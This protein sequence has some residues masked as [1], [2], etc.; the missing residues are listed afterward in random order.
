M[1]KLGIVL[2][3]LVLLLF[4]LNSFAQDICFDEATAG[5][6]IVAL[7]QAKI[8]SQQLEVQAGSNSELQQQLEI[9]KGTIKL[10]EDQ[11]VVYKNIQDMNKQMSDA[12][13]KLHEQELKAVKP[14]FWD[15]MQKYIVG[16]GIGAAVAVAI[17]LIL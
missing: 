8:A 16:G 13:D 1:K 9:L 14:T 10:M 11:I 4:P 5:R 3:L 7:E 12:K 15:N 6:M 17:I 2:L